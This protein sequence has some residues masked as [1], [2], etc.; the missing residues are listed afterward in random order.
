MPVVLKR[1]KPPLQKDAKVASGIARALQNQ[2]L[3]FLM[4]ILDKRGL[5]YMAFKHIR[6]TAELAD[7]GINLAAEIQQ[8]WKYSNEN[9]PERHYRRGS[10]G[11]GG[12]R[13]NRDS[14]LPA[15]PAPAPGL[16]PMPREG[17]PTSW[18]TSCRRRCWPT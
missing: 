4:D 8:I 11:G 9:P 15:P 17:A 1:K 16:Q 7:I 18:C 13:L 12:Q 2:D 10:G 14:R 6:K 3:D 5:A